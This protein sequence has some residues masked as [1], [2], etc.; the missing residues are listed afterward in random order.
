[1]SLHE[2]SVTTP[3]NAASIA[4]VLIDFSNKSFIVLFDCC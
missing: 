4:T 1:L 2:L 3:K